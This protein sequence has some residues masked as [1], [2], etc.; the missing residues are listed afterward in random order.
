M[1]SKFK[2]TWAASLLGG[3][4]WL[5]GSMAGWAQGQYGPVT[6]AD[7]VGATFDHYYDQQMKA[8][9][10]PDFEWTFGHGQ[11]TIKA[12][13]KPIAAELLSLLADGM[14]DVRTIV[15]GWKL[16]DGKLTISG[17]KV[18]GKPTRTMAFL[19]VIWTEPTVIRIGDHQYAFVPK[20]RR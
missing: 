18:N 15:A 20:P 9:V 4:V 17:I 2:R 13:K 8:V 16:E 3:A 10:P 5:A 7:L 6:A 14:K 19:G 11:L 12:G 1:K